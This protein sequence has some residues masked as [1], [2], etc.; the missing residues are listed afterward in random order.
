MPF[1]NFHAFRIKSPGL[2]SR[3]VVLRTLDNGIM[4]YGGPLKSNPSGETTA[5]TYRFPK[6]RFTFVEAK[7]WMS[8]H[9]LKYISAEKASDKTQAFSETIQLNS[10]GYRNAKSLIESGKVD[11]T[12]PWSFTTEDKNKIL[13]SNENWQN[14]SKW[15]LAIDTSKNANVK[16]HYG[17]PFGKDG[18]VYRSALRA[19][20]TRSGQYNQSNISN[21]AGKLLE[22]LN[23]K[24]KVQA[25][26]VR[27]LL[28]IRSFSQNKIIELIPKN[29]YN[30]ILKKD[31]HPFFAMYS[32]CHEGISTPVIIDE[33]PKKIIWPRKAIQS[34]KNIWTK[35][36][37]LFKG[38]NKDSS[39]SGRKVIGYVIHSFQ[40]EIEG[41]LH[42]IVITYHSPKVRNEVKDLDVCSQEAEWNFFDYAKQLIAD[43]IEKLTGIALANSKKELPAFAQAKRLGYV[44]AFEQDFKSV[45][46]TNLKNDIGGKNYMAKRNATDQ[47]VD[48]IFSQD[49]GS[50]DGFQDNSLGNGGFPN[51]PNIPPGWCYDPNIGWHKPPNNNKQ[52]SNFQQQQNYQQPN[53]QQQQPNFRQSNNQQN[54]RIVKEPITYEDL[55]KAK[56]DMKLFPSQLFTEEDLRKD[57]EFVKLF[58]D[59]QIAQ[60][61]NDK[62]DRRIEELMREKELVTAKDR[63]A[64]YMQDEKL[65]DDIVNFIQGEFEEDKDEIEDLSDQG[66]KSF[67]EK[68]TALFQ[69]TAKIVNPEFDIKQKTG[70]DKKGGS[71]DDFTKAEDNEL[72]E[73]DLE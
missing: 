57:R 13:G 62:K 45:G 64:G 31:K 30:K 16:G 4:I 14:Y 5:Q 67:V 59:L 6:S 12:S 40:K 44:Q 58:N 73:D 36:V 23:K 35:G 10:I 72:L 28:N 9:N 47:D 65:P 22:M 19:I 61:E 63:I 71:G 2:F 27:L 11:N 69:K 52:P 49:D 34:I 42:H 56:V 32:I 55:K 1:P 3:I 50:Q 20:R 51:L 70:D 25:F 60:E 46:K 48:N 41:K 17:Y 43:K 68:K 7:K 15:F 18:K 29:T 54:S 37:K 39:H 8:D 66:L 33:G 21:A 26:T 53:F 38:H 24:R